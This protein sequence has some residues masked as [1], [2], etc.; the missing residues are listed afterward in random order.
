MDRRRNVQAFSIT[1]FALALPVAG[2]VWNTGQ[3][4]L[5][6]WVNRWH[7]SWCDAVM[8][9]ITHLADGLVPTAIAVFLLFIGTWRSFLMLGLSTG[10]SAIAVQLL[11]RQVFAD[12]DRPVMFARDMPLLHLVDGVTMNHH[13]S[14]PSGHATCAFAMCLSFAVLGRRVGAAPAWAALAA[15]L[16]FSRVYLSQHFTEDVLAGALLGTATGAL[17]WALLYRSAWSRSP[18]L[19]RRPWPQGR[20]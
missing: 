8:R 15:L 13:F 5:H 4:D 19:E 12:H 1:A 16:S 17:V 14:F 3:L 7:A 9:T 18:W 10:L 6:A 2:A 11:K 20:R